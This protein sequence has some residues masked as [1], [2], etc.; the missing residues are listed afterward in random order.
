MQCMEDSI[1]QQV[2]VGGSDGGL[3][4]E[5]AYEDFKHF[6]EVALSRKYFLEISY[7]ITL[8][9]IEGAN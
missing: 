6:S 3:I 7:C 9:S 2:V 5:Y 1:A 8:S 4:E